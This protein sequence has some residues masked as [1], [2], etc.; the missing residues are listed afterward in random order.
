[1]PPDSASF[2]ALWDK[3]LRVCTPL[4]CAVIV[5]VVLSLPWGP[6]WL[7]LIKGPLLVMIAGI[8]A[9]APR[10]YRV[11]GDY[12]IIRRLIGDVRIPLQGLRQAR[13]MSPEELR[14]T[15]QIWAVGCFFGYFGKFLTGVESQIWYVTDTQR[16]VR[17]DCPPHIVVISPSDPVAFM[18]ALPSLPA[19]AGSL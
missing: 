11:E 18:S 19:R 4:I 1:M 7:W 12:L 16:C 6:V 10:A 14:G 5:F 2:A 17:L 3:R 9:W 8:W 15:V 13:L